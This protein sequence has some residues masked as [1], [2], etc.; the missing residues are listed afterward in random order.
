MRQLQ[1]S[2]RCRLLPG[3]RLVLDERLCAGCDIGENARLDVGQVS[4]YG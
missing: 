3:R 1:S 4:E 2:G